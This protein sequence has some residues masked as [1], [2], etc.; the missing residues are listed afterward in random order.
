MHNRRKHEYDTQYETYFFV[1]IG[2]FVGWC[3]CFGLFV[4]I[5]PPHKVVKTRPVECQ[6]GYWHNKSDS[7]ILGRG[8]AFASVAFFKGYFFYFKIFKLYFCVRITTLKWL[9]VRIN[10][11][12]ERFVYVKKIIRNYNW[13]LKLFLLCQLTHKYGLF[14]F[15]SIDKK[16]LAVK[17]AC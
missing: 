6:I 14:Y 10:V 1:V 12:L 4:V 8:L 9:S 3:C 13:T 7:E 17:C 5:F 15:E 11:L 2:G 16:V